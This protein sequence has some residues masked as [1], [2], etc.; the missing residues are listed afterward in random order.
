M[1]AGGGVGGGRW[2][3]VARALPTDLVTAFAAVVFFWGL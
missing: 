3:G 1:G 2:V